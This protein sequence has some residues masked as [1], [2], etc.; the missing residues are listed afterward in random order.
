MENTVRAMMG[1][2]ANEG[3]KP[4]DLAFLSEMR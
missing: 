4:Y 2:I 3:S 1:L